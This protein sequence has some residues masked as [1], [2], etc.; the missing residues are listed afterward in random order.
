LDHP[1]IVKFKDVFVTK[2]AK[3]SI[4]MEYADGIIEYYVRW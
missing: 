4:V 1:N 2:K 3:L